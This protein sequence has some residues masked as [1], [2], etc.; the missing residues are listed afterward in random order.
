[1]SFINGRQVVA[2]GKI[3]GVDLEPVIAR[4]NALAREMVARHPMA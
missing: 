2:D 4:H 1:M 3:A